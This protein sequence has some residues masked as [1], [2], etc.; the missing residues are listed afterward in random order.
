M[1][2]LTTAEAILVPE[3]PMAT[4]PT[5]VPTGHY[6]VPQPG[7]ILTAL[8]VEQ[9]TTT[10]PGEGFGRE[11]L[12]EDVYAQML[13]NYPDDEDI[14]FNSN[15]SRKQHIKTL[16]KF[17]NNNNLKEKHN[18]SEKITFEHLLSKDELKKHGSWWDL[19]DNE[20]M[21][22]KENYDNAK[23]YLKALKFDMNHHL[24]KKENGQ[25]LTFGEFRELL[26]KQKNRKHSSGETK[27]GGSKKKSRKR[28]SRKKPKKK[29]K[30]KR[31]KKRKTKRKKSRKRKHKKGRKSIKK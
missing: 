12:Y 26:K 7:G 28:K 31:N 19:F 9:A 5:I 23:Q 14:N 3:V 13:T 20:K 21:P 27:E 17:L 30:T 15:I 2:S 16:K 10:L 25:V 29:R 22:T 18:L 24:M 8:P 4:G 6:A 11:Q 1:T